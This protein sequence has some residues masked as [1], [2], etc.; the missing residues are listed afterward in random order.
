MNKMLKNQRIMGNLSTRKC[1][2]ANETI[3]QCLGNCGTFYCI[4]CK[5]PLNVSHTKCVEGKMY[6]GRDGSSTYFICDACNPFKILDLFL[7]GPNV[8]YT[9][10]KPFVEKF[11]GFTKPLIVRDALR[12]HL[13]DDL[14]ELIQ[15]Y[16]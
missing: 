14:V 11:N 4:T 2:L 12:S 9:W 7:P 15:T 10:M 8:P 13:P 1:S 3:V 5:H 16:I 6:W